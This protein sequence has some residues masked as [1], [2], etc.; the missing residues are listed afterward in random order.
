M[1]RE[2]LQNWRENLSRTLPHP[3][4]TAPPPIINTD[5][6]IPPLLRVYV[7]GKPDEPGVLLASTPP[8][9]TKDTAPNN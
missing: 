7:P 5:P 2:K 1:S 3:R 8:P 9:E 4:T 6:A